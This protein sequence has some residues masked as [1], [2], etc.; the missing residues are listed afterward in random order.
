MAGKVGRDPANP[1]TRA[2]ANGRPHVGTFFVASVSFKTRPRQ[3][4]ECESAL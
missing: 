3:K 1:R 4:V 2:N